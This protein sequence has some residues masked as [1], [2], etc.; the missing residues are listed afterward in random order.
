[1][2]LPPPRLAL[3]VLL[4]GAIL[5]AGCS[6]R[7]AALP[8]A[9]PPAVPSTPSPV[10]SPTP[11][12][13]GPVDGVVELTVVHL[14]TAGQRVYSAGAP[15]DVPPVVDE[16]AV[17]TFVG[18]VDRWID[19]HLT[20]LQ[21]GE[22]PPLP[23]N[24]DPA[25]APEALHAVTTALASP[26]LLVAGATYVVEVAVDGDPAWAHVT[27]TVEH[28]DGGTASADLVFV[29]SADGPQLLA[30]GPTGEVAP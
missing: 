25:A 10:A 30:A 20:A 1:M 13:P 16:P 27:V 24:L 5:A 7:S 15:G 18:N 21:E 23:A 4:C 28:V 14:E 17:H 29:P 11:A 6:D 3:G 2:P 12:A 22:V 9:S 8:V 19:A 26:D